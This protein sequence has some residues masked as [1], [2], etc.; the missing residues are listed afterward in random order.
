MSLSERSA[1]AMRLGKRARILA[2]SLRQH[3]GGV[4]REVA[5]AGVARRLDR[6]ALEV[7][8]AA[9]RRLEVKAS[10]GLVDPLVEIGEDVHV[11]LWKHR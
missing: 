3:H 8:R 2:G 9:V 5:M 4:G 6:D 7:E 11:G 1:A 10:N